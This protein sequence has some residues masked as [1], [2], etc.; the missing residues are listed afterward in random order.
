M[1]I[2]LF[3]Y[4]LTFSR[5]NVENMVYVDGT[6]QEKLIWFRFRT[7]WNK[8]IDSGRVSWWDITIANWMFSMGIWNFR[9]LWMRGL[10]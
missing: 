6:K 5:L 4:R 9:G 7:P 2:N 3:N 1:K 8:P 10:R